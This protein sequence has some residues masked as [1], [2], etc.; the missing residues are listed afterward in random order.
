MKKYDILLLYVCST[1]II[2]LY[3]FK[4]TIDFVLERTWDTAAA[5][6]SQEKNVCNV[7]GNQRYFFNIAYFITL[8]SVSYHD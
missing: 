7:S 1:N 3:G 2:S 5:A 4:L 6:C 8:K